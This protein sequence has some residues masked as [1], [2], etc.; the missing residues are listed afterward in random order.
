[1]E[2]RE[3]PLAWKRL[4]GWSIL[5]CEYI[6]KF[7]TYIFWGDGT[8]GPTLSYPY[9]LLF[10]SSLDPGDNRITSADLRRF[11]RFSLMPVLLVRQGGVQ[12]T[13]ILSFITSGYHSW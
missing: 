4:S 1:M 6:V 10:E 11:L 9:L 2:E 13:A 12:C 5:G 7:T 8:N 3:N